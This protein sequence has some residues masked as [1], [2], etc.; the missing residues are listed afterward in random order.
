MTNNLSDPKREKVDLDK[1]ALA[2]LISG[3]CSDGNKRTGHGAGAGRGKGAVRGYAEGV[4]LQLQIS[5]WHFNKE[6]ETLLLLVCSLE[7]ETL[8]KLCLR[9]PHVEASCIDIPPFFPTFYKGVED[10]GSAPD[11][12]R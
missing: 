2:C 12:K 10:G 11:K 7:A 9:I 1:S 6:I 4:W 8:Q 5:F 3:I